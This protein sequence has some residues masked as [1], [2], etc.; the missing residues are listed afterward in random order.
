[1]ALVPWITASAISTDSTSV[2]GKILQ[3]VS[4]SG[5][6]IAGWEYHSKSNPNNEFVLSKIIFMTNVKVTKKMNAFVMLDFRNF[7]LQEMW[8]SYSFL[9]EVNVKLGQFKTPFS[10]ESPLSPSRLELITGTSLV[11][12]EMICGG[13]PLMM[14][15]AAGRDLGITVYGSL[16][17]GFVNYDLALMSGTGRNKRDNNSQKDFAARVSVNPFEFLRLRGSALVGTGNVKLTQVG[18]EYVCD[19]VPELTDVKANGNFKRR[20]YAAGAE[21]K[22]APVDVRGEWMWGKDGNLSSDGCYVTSAIKNVATKGLEIVASYDHLKNYV[23]ARNRYTAG[24]QYWFLKR[25]RVQ[26]GYSY[27]KRCGTGA[28]ESSFYTYLQ[29]AF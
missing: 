16:F 23:G 10:I 21:L 3:R 19:E 7:N 17:K 27:D 25:C 11:T 1:M 24:L 9:P 29:L 18:D 26:A 6:A 20:R 12:S 2:I 22:T 5:Y 13:S 8:M 14:P 28:G 15:G 4:F